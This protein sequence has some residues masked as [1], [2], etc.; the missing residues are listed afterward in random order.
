MPGDV[1]QQGQT[2]V[3]LSIYTPSLH[4]TAG[5]AWGKVSCHAFRPEL[6]SQ[7]GALHELVSQTYDGCNLNVTSTCSV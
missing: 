3:I 1:G 6:A 5:E 4:S 7:E 2:R